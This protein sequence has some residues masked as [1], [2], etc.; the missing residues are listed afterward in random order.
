VVD[1]ARSSLLRISIIAGLVSIG[2]GVAQAIHQGLMI[3]MFERP[4]DEPDPGDRRD[5][6]GPP[7]E[8]QRR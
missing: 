7:D 5:R 8:D 6:D 2:Y 1:T 3:F 4:L